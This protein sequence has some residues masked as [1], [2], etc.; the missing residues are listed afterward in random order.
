M[1]INI[2]KIL[3]AIGMIS[4]QN[5]TMLGQNALTDAFKNIEY[6]GEIESTISDKKTPLWLN[7]NKY[8]VS[9]TEGD[10]GVLRLGIK[11]KTSTDSLRKWRIGY[12]A[13]IAA[14][15]GLD[16]NSILPTNLYTD[17][18]YKKV[19]IS[20]GIKEREIAFKNNKLSSGGQTF[21]KNAAPIPEIRFELPNYISI[22]GKS[23]WAA[24][25]G[26]FG[27]GWMTDGKWQKNYVP[28]G[29]RYAKG[30][31]YHSKA[32]YLKI[33]NEEKFPLTFEGGLEMACQFG[34]TI[35]YPAGRDGTYADKLVIKTGV[36]EYINAIFGLGSDATDEEYANAAGNTVG[37]WLMSLKYHG[38]NWSARVYYDHYF[39]DH[40]MMFL[41]YGWRDGMIGA[42]IELP[43]N[44]IC[45][46]MVYEY[47]GTTY[48]SG[49]IYHDHT[50]AIPDQ[51][52]GIDNYYNHNLYQGWQ[53]WGQGIGNPLLTSPL[54]KNDK[55]LNFS[56]NRIK[57]HHIGLQGTP[58]NGLNYRLLFSHTKSWG[59]YATPLPN[60]L[61]QNNF[62]CELT[63]DIP[64]NAYKIIAKP[65]LAF[66]NNGWK[67]RVAYALDRGDLTGNSN[68]FM[69]GISK[70]GVLIK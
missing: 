6:K 70:S 41:Q 67:V 26:H 18:E 14:G 52:S 35:Y 43:N 38:K 7:A 46:T 68:G 36:K 22:T 23:K 61:Q 37:S 65:R 2:G 53:H 39:E 63:Y 12:E 21:G 9:G 4:I 51:I 34:G 13:E 57:S 62:L 25:K 8:G 20:V 16:G 11:H 48:Q 19:R 64:Y 31:R 27:Y 50:T 55:T 44:P 30:V 49:P 17:F 32:G 10:F 33:G 3:L 60:I 24:I 40:S 69:L 59:T 47:L 15:Y 58:Y 29:N 66:W 5:L 54:Y 42:E 28:Q 1:E 56:S 45:N